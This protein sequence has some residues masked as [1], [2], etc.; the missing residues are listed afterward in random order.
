MQGTSFLL[1]SDASFELEAEKKTKSIANRLKIII[2]QFFNYLD[3]AVENSFQ[4]SSGFVIRM[5]EF[6]LISLIE[7]YQWPKSYWNDAKFEV[8]YKSE[9]D[10]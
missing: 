1:S 10:L 9:I 5:I 6:K 7:T 4:I 3:W 8:L 2:L